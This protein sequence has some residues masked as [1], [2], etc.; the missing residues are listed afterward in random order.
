MRSNLVIKAEQGLATFY[1]QDIKKH[2]IFKRRHGHI[3]NTL[4]TFN[5]CP[6]SKGYDI[7]LTLLL[8]IS[9]IFNS[10]IILQFELEDVFPS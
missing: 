5:L 7:V 6:V 8:L 10:F 4:C 9:I 2:M 3:L 1:I